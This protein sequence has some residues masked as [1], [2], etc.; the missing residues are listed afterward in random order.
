M[1]ALLW[2]HSLPS[3]GQLDC[4]PARV[5]Q[6]V[7]SVFR[8]NHFYAWFTLCLAMVLG[9]GTVLLLLH[10]PWA[11]R[12]GERTAHLLAAVVV[13]AGSFGAAAWAFSRRCITDSDKLVLVSLFER[14][15]VCRW[16]EVRVLVD[17]RN[18]SSLL[19]YRQGRT[20]PLLLSP[21][22]YESPAELKNLIR[23]SVPS[24]SIRD[25][26]DDPER[27]Q[28]LL[29]QLPLRLVTFGW[30]SLIGLLMTGP[31]LTGAGLLLGAAVSWSVYRLAPLYDHN[32]WWAWTQMVLIWSPPLLLV[33][34][35]EFIFPQLSHGGLFIAYSY[36]LGTFAVDYLYRRR[37]KHRVD[38]RLRQLG[39]LD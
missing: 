16:N 35:A 37:L 38:E 9:S 32:R 34:A 12:Y 20:D 36:F 13:T 25:V 28:N 29:R 31:V 3:P 19:L 8:G 4:S 39:V 7:M 6:Q 5:L 24:E 2:K 14:K 10:D 22:T 1:E 30:F 26:P 21:V 17:V 15:T 33:A 11:D 23:S 27:D 18:G